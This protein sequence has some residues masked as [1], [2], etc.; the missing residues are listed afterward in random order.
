MGRAISYINVFPTTQREIKA[1]VDQVLNEVDNP[2]DLLT[3]LCM[4]EL[5]IRGIREG[6][7]T[8]IGDDPVHCPLCDCD[9][10]ESVCIFVDKV[11][12]VCRQCVTNKCLT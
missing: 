8:P 7:K 2:L 5:I 9:T 4:M 1:F 12:F 6:I 11:G 10:W 3:R